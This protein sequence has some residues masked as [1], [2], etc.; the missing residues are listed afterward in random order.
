MTFNLEEEATVVE[1]WTPI[2]SIKAYD[3]K[4]SGFYDITKRIF[5]LRERIES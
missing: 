1:L 5:Q 2:M 4:T 3:G